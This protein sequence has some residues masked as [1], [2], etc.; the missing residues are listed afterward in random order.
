VGDDAQVFLQKLNAR[1]KDSAWMYRLP[2]E[3]EWEYA[4][5]GGASSKEGCSYHYYLDQPSNS[6]SST[7]ANFDGNYPNGEAAKGPYL[8][9]T[10]KVGSYQANRLGIFDMHGNVWE[11]CHDWYDAR[12]SLRVF[13]GGG[14]INYARNCR[15]ADG[16]AIE[17]SSRRLTLGMRLARVPSGSQ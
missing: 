12:A 16:Y 1:E 15:A 8:E 10:S 3:A 13:R 17:P 7:Q 6:L 11:W 5:R 9:R 4:C 2:T 14:W